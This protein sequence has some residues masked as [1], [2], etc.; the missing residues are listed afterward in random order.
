MFTK[1]QRMLL[2]IFAACAAPFVLGTLAFFFYQPSGRINYGELLE[3]KPVSLPEGVTLSGA[4][5]NAAQFTGKWWVIHTCSADCETELYAT[6]QA[7]TMLNKDMD[8]LQRVVLVG[9]APSP[10]LKAK[11]PDAQWL[12]GSPTGS[13]KADAIVLLDA[14]E[15]QVLAWPKAPDIKRV[16]KD[17]SRL[18]RV[19]QRG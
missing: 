10:E 2:L 15:N 17:L 3:V 18:M 6:R 5:L 8:R 19:N 16:H 1:Q 4:T 9:A 11:H 12:I 13:P 14:E 7:R